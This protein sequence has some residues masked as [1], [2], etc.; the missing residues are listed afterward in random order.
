MPLT[1]GTRGI[2][3]SDPDPEDFCSI[4]HD[5][6]DRRASGDNKILL[7]RRCNHAFHHGCLW[8]WLNSVRAILNRP[9]KCPMCRQLMNPHP[10]NLGQQEPRAN[11]LALTRQ[12]SRP[13][14]ALHFSVDFYNRTS[15][16]IGR[17]TMPHSPAIGAHL[18]RAIRTLS[19]EDSLPACLVPEPATG[20]Y[21]SIEARYRAEAEEQA[22]FLFPQ[23]DNVSI[24][25]FAESTWQRRTP[26]VRDLE[27]LESLCDTLLSFNNL[28][29]YE[30]WLAYIE[31]S[32]LLERLMPR[33]ARHTSQNVHIDIAFPQLSIEARLFSLMTP[34]E[35]QERDGEIE[36]NFGPSYYD[37]PILNDVYARI[38]RRM[39]REENFAHF[40]EQ[41]IYRHYIDVPGNVR[42]GSPS[43]GRETSL[44]LGQQVVRRTSRSRH[45]VHA[46]PSHTSHRRVASVSLR[47]RDNGAQSRSA[48]QPC[49]RPPEWA[50]G[51]ADD[52]TRNGA[53]LRS[54]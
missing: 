49:S 12:N 17:H 13:A 1:A 44:S 43:D 45:S 46:H 9:E 40:V 36:R 11:T 29:G 37:S 26:F 25:A 16:T 47:H 34:D 24:H 28:D 27:R 42:D 53:S 48:S 8:T 23:W 10:R 19:G 51:Q 35:E 2:T 6:F 52:G 30:L 20:T 7:V 14:G 33:Q 41:G 3:P 4:C 18:V 22:Q 15:L 39:R 31:F 32:F 21:V 50:D 54:G 5:D 38:H